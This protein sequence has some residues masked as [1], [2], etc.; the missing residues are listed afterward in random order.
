VARVGH[1]VAAVAEDR[2]GAEWRRRGRRHG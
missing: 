1:D 2:Q